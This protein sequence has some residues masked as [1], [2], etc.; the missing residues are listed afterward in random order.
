MTFLPSSLL[1]AETGA[2][3]GLLMQVVT[4]LVGVV[5]IDRVDRRAVLVHAS[6][7]ACCAVP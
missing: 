7:Q 5:I 6:M 4:T 1:D 3:H 2:M